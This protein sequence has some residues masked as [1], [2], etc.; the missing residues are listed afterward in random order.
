MGHFFL[1][2]LATTFFS[3][4]MESYSK[5]ALAVAMTWLPSLVLL[6]VGG[7]WAD[8]ATPTR[9]WKIFELLN[10]FLCLGLAFAFYHSHIA[11]ILSFLFLKSLVEF[12]LR[13]AR[14]A[15]FVQL[16]TDFAVAQLIATGQSSL[17]LGFAAAGILGFF[18]LENFSSDFLA[19]VCSIFFLM[20][21]LFVSRMEIK[22]LERP[23]EKK[24]VSILRAFE[25]VWLEPATRFHF[26]MLALWAGLLQGSFSVLQNVLPETTFEAGKSG[27]SLTH[28]AASLG[29][30]A[31]AIFF[32]TLDHRFRISSQRHPWLRKEYLLGTASVCG[33]Y[34][35]AAFSQNPW[36]AL[37]S[38]AGFVFVFEVF[39]M[40]FLVSCL[41]LSPVA[42]KGNVT[43]LIHSFIPISQS[44]IAIATGSLIAYWQAGPLVLVLCL[45]LIV[46]SFYFKRSLSF[47][48][49]PL[50]EQSL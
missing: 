50:T 9:F 37:L 34:L 46:S 28:F 13:V 42:E 20:P 23:V 26:V 41:N 3:V 22:K 24:G 39:F 1:L 16:K 5:T 7:R 45:I 31:G 25:V 18:V 36:V 2:I 27:I 38:F 35:L 47:L 29:I 19:V 11:L 10:F 33:L 32:Q 15:T 40:A 4:V 44:V 43:A 21:L 14:N 6:F 12:L 49:K 8:K 30:L 17:Y 48:G